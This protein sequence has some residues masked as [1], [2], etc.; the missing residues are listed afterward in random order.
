MTGIKT[1]LK[2]FDF[3]DWFLLSAGITAFILGLLSLTGW[4]E[5]NIQQLLPIILGALGLLMSA[6]VVQSKREEATS[7]ELRLALDETLGG[8]L[9][10]NKFD[11]VESGVAYLANRVS[12]AKS[13][14]DQASLSLPFNRRHASVRDYE[15]A[16]RNAALSNKA[17]IRYIANFVDEARLKRVRDILSNSAV[18]KYKVAHFSAKS[19]VHPLNFS[20]ID[21]EEIILSIPAGLGREDQFLSIWNPKI[22]SAFSHYFN[23]LYHKAT[24]IENISQL[25]TITI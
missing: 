2:S 24:E 13:S 17:N 21:N 9:T 19:I 20:I 14:I 18:S 22:V 12:S 11:K 4:I 10:I 3:N 7:K 15:R 8:R 1:F 6:F 16:I 25:D 23:L 5:L